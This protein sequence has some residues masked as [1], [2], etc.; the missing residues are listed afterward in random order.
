MLRASREESLQHMRFLARAMQQALTRL[1]E[2]EDLS[3]ED[4]AALVQNVSDDLESAAHRCHRSLGHLSA[5]MASSNHQHH[6]PPPDEHQ[7][8]TYN[9]NRSQNVVNVILKDMTSILEE[10]Q[11][12]TPAQ[13]TSYQEHN[14]GYRPPYNVRPDTTS[15]EDDS[16]SIGP[17]TTLNSGVGGLKHSDAVDDD[18]NGE[19]RRRLA[20]LK[21]CVKLPSE[22]TTSWAD[23]IG[24]ESALSA[25]QQ[26][27]V[28]PIKFPQFFTQG[29]NPWK[30][31]LLYGPPGT[32]KTMLAM[33]S[34]R[35]AQATLIAISAADLLSKY[36]GESEKT[37]RQIFSMAKHYPRVVLF[38]DEIDALCGTRGAEGE[39]E[40]AR[41][42]K[43]E[44]LIRI[45]EID[46][47]KVLIIAATNVPWELDSAFR[48]RFEQL[49][50]VPLPDFNARKQM[51]MKRLGANVVASEP[52]SPLLH[53]RRPPSR[54]ALSYSPQPS[55]AALPKT[56]TPT[57]IAHTLDASAF[58][59][60]ARLTEGYS[61]SDLENV[62]QHAMMLPIQT[63]QQATHFRRI[64]TPIPHTS[65]SPAAGGYTTKTPHTHYTSDT[66]HQFGIW[67][68]IPSD[69]RHPDAVRTSLL[70]LPSDEVHLEPVSEQDF[71][72]ACQ[73]Y[74]RS[75]SDDEI[76]RYSK[77][78]QQLR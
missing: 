39:S 45:N 33:A 43:T 78:H 20:D 24:A 14:R 50:Y 13:E 22:V 58:D 44:F 6:Q 36:V 72:A 65:P 10:L 77:W 75:S 28:L 41:R 29:L 64:Y 12:P 70:Q 26:A 46:R 42:V 25:L 69:P 74:Q 18:A 66:H 73:K 40:S 5:L 62:I 34:A 63:M 17:T 57:P 16:A 4:R 19:E 21:A 53:H 7:Q 54:D 38:L 35:E 68:W 61:G 60:I 8:H 76:E 30:R 59:H 9:Q 1:K 49:I 52:P 2:D 11:R 3:P 55:P 56:T 67:R 47:N 23:V 27:I 71:E 31:L 32:G 51:I 15:F 37:I 48:R